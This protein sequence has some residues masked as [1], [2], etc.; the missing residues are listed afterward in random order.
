[1]ARRVALE[2][3]HT[4]VDYNPETGEF[5][6]RRCLHATK[7]WNDTHEGMPAGDINEDGYL[8]IQI[9][10]RVY[11]AHRMAF[12]IMTGRQPTG[13]IVDHIDRVRT[14]NKWSNL[15]L[16]TIAQNSANQSIRVDNQ[17]GHKGVSFK[18]QTGRWLARIT[19]EGKTN[20]LGYFDTKEEAASAYMAASLDIHGEFSTL[21]PSINWENHMARFRTKKINTTTAAGIRVTTT[22]VV[23]APELEWKLQAAAV[24]ALRNLPEFDATFTL[25]G[26]FNAARRS[27][28]ESTKAKATGLTPGEHDLRIYMLQGRLGLIEFK[29]AK[30]RLSPEQ[31]ARH[32]LLRTLGFTM[33]A[34]VK[35]STEEE[36][37]T[38]TLALV[39]TWLAANDNQ[40]A[41]NVGVAKI[42]G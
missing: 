18:K 42:I 24:K 3:P 29:G 39:R 11:L 14:N 37:A 25:A 34:V 5:I 9:N 20:H 2:A 35:A 36:A 1:M 31:A 21:R 12:V 41:E 13:K 33:Q 15:R 32:G 4:R 19:T 17:T 23:K 16:A 26:D 40:T 6:W 27:P 30:G 10:N 22:K 38:A 8:T 7:E 28:Q